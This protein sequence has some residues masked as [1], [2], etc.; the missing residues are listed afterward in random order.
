[1]LGLW[2]KREMCGLHLPLFSLAQADCRSARWM[3]T[4]RTKRSK[5]STIGNIQVLAYMAKI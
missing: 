3:T 4:Y 5:T 1:V 2:I